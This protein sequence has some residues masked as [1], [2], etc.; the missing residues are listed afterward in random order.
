MSEAL[1]GTARQPTAEQRAI[2]EASLDPMLVIAGA[3]S[4]KTTTMADRVV[5][6]VANR[7]AKP[8]EILGVTFTRK[9]AGELAAKIRAKLRILGQQNPELSDVLGPDSL[10]AEISTYHSYASGIVSD[11]GLRIGVERDATVLGQAQ[12]WQ[13][14]SKIVEA[15]DGDLSRYSG[16]SSTLV[17]AVISLASECAEH[18]QNPRD[19][20]TWLAALRDE[21]EALPLNTGKGRGPAGKALELA[22]RLDIRAHVAQMVQQYQLAKSQRNALDYG[23]LV[24]LAAKLALNV[25]E[26]AEQ[27]RLKHRVVLLDEF[28]DTSHAQLTLFAALF[29]AGHPVTAVGDPHQSIYGFRGASAGQLFRFPGIFRRADGQPAETAALTVAWRNSLSIL[30][31]A[32][33]MSSELNR[34]AEQGHAESSTQL[35]PL[36]PRPGAPR[37]EVELSRFGTENEEAQAVADRI[38]ARRSVRSQD[39][40]VAILCRRRTQF[41][42]LQTALEAQNI[43]YEIVGLSGLLATPEVIDV[44]STLRVLVDPTRSDALMRLMTGARWRIGSKDLMALADWSKFLVA[45]AKRARKASPTVIDDVA[46]AASLIE[47]IDA[48]DADYWPDSARELSATG[49]QRL[50][51]LRDELRTLRRFVGDDLLS[52]ISEVERTIL[53]DIELAAKPG[54]SYHR[55]RHHLDAFQDAASSFLQ[56]AERVDVLAFLAWLSAADGEEGGLEMLPVEPK[57]GAVQLLTVHAAKGLEWDE[58]YVP[59]L[60]TKSFPS[61][62]ADHWGT[63]NRALPWPLRGD[64]ADLPEWKLQGE[65]QRTWIGELA[66]FTE[67]V[68]DHALQEERRLAYVAYTRAR[69]FLAVSTSKFAGTSV[70]AKEIS[71]FLTEL[72][73]VAEQESAASYGLG[74][75]H[76]PAEQHLPEENPEREAVIRAQWPFDPLAGPYLKIGEKVVEPLGS[77]RAALLS[78]AQRVQAARPSE[79]S[80]PELSAR[81]GI[82][83]KRL[84][85]QRTVRKQVID[86]ELPTHISASTLV[87]LRVNPAAVVAQI[88]RPVPRK[89]GLAARKGT[90]FHAWVESYFGRAGQLDLGEF[91]GAADDFV[92]DAY[93]LEQ[94]RENFEASE[95]A[96]KQPSEI[97]VPIETKIAGVVV[98]G[99]IDAVFQDADGGWELVDW[100][101]GQLPKGKELGDRSVQLALYRLGWARLKGIAVEKVRAAFYYAARNQTERVLDLAGEQELESIISQ[102]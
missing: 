50:L 79:L 91:P 43:D 5:H 41:Q 90:A 27:E 36:Q 95:W 69:S 23:D 83:A 25:P 86:V 57:S 20:E 37:G 48:L 45:S 73:D 89:P 59:G 31:S 75:R 98:R 6:L 76:W 3:G 10:E 56:S 28:Q 53:L 64:R 101:T 87:E 82:E 74:F 8:E 80:L 29:G 84:L 18:L 30:E 49:L 12:C 85:E 34:R 54:I 13:L 39:V 58:V 35:S 9:A 65:D 102:A 92:E 44:V 51:A 72:V 77:R 1:S 24:A 88:R 17:Q 47:A 70:R 66:E 33:A 100:K 99:R 22:D 38:L 46:E 93:Q 97:E 62:R 32:N 26:V 7:L 21:F 42:A 11:Y 68:K 61:D 78:A 40:S 67:S 19:V 4:G 2:I 15:Y 60:A 71:P 14:A 81:W 63:G 96:A 55:A 94:L 52:L 16:A